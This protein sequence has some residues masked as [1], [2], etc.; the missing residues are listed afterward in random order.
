MTISQ[1]IMAEHSG[2][3]EVVECSSGAEFV[4]TIPRKQEH[5]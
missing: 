4:L 3:I 5:A 1:R 2:T